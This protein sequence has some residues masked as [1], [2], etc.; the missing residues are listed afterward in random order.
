MLLKKYCK[1]ADGK[2]LLNFEYHFGKCNQ[3]VEQCATFVQ[4]KN[5]YSPACV[6]RIMRDGILGKVTNKA[7]LFPWA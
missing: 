7:W 3:S 4:L 5:I 1:K 2:A 6:K